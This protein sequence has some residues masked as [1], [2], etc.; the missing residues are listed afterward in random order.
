MTIWIDIEDLLA[1]F[2]HATR[3]S[4]IQRLCFEIYR[5]LWRERGASG[6]VRFVRHLP[7]GQ[8]FE[9]VAW[10][11]VQNRIVEAIDDTPAPALGSVEPVPVSVPMTLEMPV[12]EGLPVVP[13]SSLRQWGRG[14]PAD[15]RAP[16]AAFVRAQTNSRD[17]VRHSIHLLRTAG[18][19]QL[20]GARAA[21]DLMRGGRRW[22]GLGGTG[23][24]VPP[25][26]SLPQAHG[27]APAPAQVATNDV[28]APPIMVGKP[29]KPERG[30]VILSIGASWPGGYY[31]AMIAGMKARFG[32]RFGVMIYDLI[33]LNWPEWAVYSLRQAF[34]NWLAPMVTEADVLFTISNATAGDIIVFAAKK[35]I[36]I[37]APQIVPIGVTFPV[38]VSRQPL[39]T[40]PYV[41]FVS[42]IEIRKN[43]T[44]MFRL[45]RR[46]I[47]ELPPD[48]IPDLIFA[49]KIGWQ[50][51][52]L[53]AQIKNSSALDG[54]LKI[55][56]GPSDSDLASLYQHCLFTVFP[57]F[58]EGWGLPI[59]ESLTFG[60]TVAAS[61]RASVPEAG[62]D[63]CTY[64]DPDDMNDAYRVISQ[65]ILE[66]ERVAALEAK[67]AAEFHPPS[68]AD[69]AAAII[70][71]VGEDTGRDPAMII[72][73]TYPS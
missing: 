37:R 69:S 66:P 57:S 67:I 72:E 33:P 63:F 31:P 32:V 23:A 35:G 26:Q 62:G 13:V 43:H 47:N 18:R 3:P 24:L 48:C 5:E 53:L 20:H 59:T 11:D 10:L 58:Y 27:Q 36:A 19:A 4:G 8:D 49:G 1:H 25:P 9:E 73:T 39:Q 41:L 52:D 68:W 6:G 54:K 7:N 28:Q 30:D 42:T 15:L 12:D 16:I 21:V 29:I 56:E 71:A 14:L 44:M 51:Q 70:A 61:N 40:R 38:R 65:L 55:V 45:W 64:F 50:T 60:K 46:M 17:A 22:L 2:Y 34:G